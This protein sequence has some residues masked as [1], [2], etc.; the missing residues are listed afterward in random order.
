MMGVDLGCS[1]VRFMHKNTWLGF[2]MH[3]DFG[4]SYY[5]LEVTQPSLSW[6]H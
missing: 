3:R 4:L 2:G 1:L 5:F 6:S